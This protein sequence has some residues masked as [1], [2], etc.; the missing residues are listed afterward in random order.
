MINY[1]ED[2]ENGNCILWNDNAGTSG[3]IRKG[4]IRTDYKQGT[5]ILDKDEEPTGEFEQIPIEV[6][7]YQELLDKNNLP[8]T[9]PDYIHIQWITDKQR[10]AKIALDSQLKINSES[11]AYLSSTDWYELRELRD[12]TKPTPQE[13]IDK[14][15]AARDSIK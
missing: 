9:D 8:E 5:E 12:T 4:K 3:F 14:R 10:K 11:L 7:I 13:I 1:I 2:S 6:D 15:Q